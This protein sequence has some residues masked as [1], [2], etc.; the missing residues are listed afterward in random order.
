MVE[1]P[2]DNRVTLVVEL[3][4]LVVERQED[5]R[6]KTLAMEKQQQ[7]ILVVA[8]E[9]VDQLLHQETVVMVV[10]EL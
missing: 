3:V 9:V 4:E 8:V 7:L 5:R 6:A 2:Q 1:V 10:A